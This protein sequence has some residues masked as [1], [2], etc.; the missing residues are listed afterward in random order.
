MPVEYSTLLESIFAP[1]QGCDGHISISQVLTYLRCPESYKRRYVLGETEP[2]AAALI[3][4]GAHHRALEQNNRH[5]LDLGS[6]LSVEDHADRFAAT[7]SDAVKEA[8]SDLEWAEDETADG[9]ITRGRKLIEAYHGSIDVGAERVRAEA[10]PCSIWNN[11]VQNTR[12]GII[13][14]TRPRLCA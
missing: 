4:G 11:G 14:G 10:S 6:D 5:K 9:V 12:P 8:G 1:E 7:F 13:I 3:E 2:P